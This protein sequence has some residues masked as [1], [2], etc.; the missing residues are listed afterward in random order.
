MKSKFSFEPSD[1]EACGQ[2]VIRESARRGCGDPSFATTVSY[3]VGYMITEGRNT[4]L[5][6]S[7]ADGLAKPFE[8]E[9]ALCHYLNSDI[10]GFRPMADEEIA[11]VMSSQRNRFHA[12]GGV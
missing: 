1:F 5:L 10:C 3:K 4:I 8:D 9:K 7:L 12:N 11:K 6:V 2:M